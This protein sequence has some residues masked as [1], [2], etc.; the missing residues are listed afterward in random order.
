MV[1]DKIQHRKQAPGSKYCSALAYSILLNIP[2][3]DAIKECG[4]TATGTYDF[5]I[6]NA[7]TKRG[8]KNHL[9]R[10]GQDWNQEMPFLRLNSYRFPIIISYHRKKKNYERGRHKESHHVVLAIDGKIFDGG[11]DSELPAEAF[12]KS[13]NTT[14]WKICNIILI[15]A[16]RSDYLKNW[17]D[18]VIDL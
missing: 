9:I 16:E 18:N 17:R 15:D 2:L 7:L 13:S 6:A 3:N 12:N 14:H 1:A 4:T 10:I 11:K 8:I 5:N